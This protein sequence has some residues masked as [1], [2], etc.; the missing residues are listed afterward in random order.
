MKLMTKRGQ[1]IGEYAILFAIVLGAVI[2]MQNYVR[3]RISEKIKEQAD[4]YS[5][6][7]VAIVSGSDS[8]STTRAT[9]TDAANGTVGGD[10]RGTSTVTT[11]E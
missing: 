4:A 10:S 5:G 6:T 9:M 2:A 11:L 8:T 3:N 7:G 1:S